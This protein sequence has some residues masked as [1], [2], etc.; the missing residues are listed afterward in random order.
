LL[1]RVLFRWCGLT[2]PSTWGRV[3]ITLV[4]VAYAIRLAGQLHPQIFIVDL[5]FHEHRLDTV[6][7]GTLLFTIES[8]EWAG[9]STYY[10]PS[11]YIFML[12][13]RW[14]IDNSQVV[15]R[16]FTVG[17]GTLGAVL[18]FLAGAVGLRSY[19]AAFIAAA[20][21]LAMP[22]SVLPFSWGITTNLFGEFF[23]LCAFT[24]LVVIGSS[25]R[26]LGPRRSAFWVL[27]ASLSVA[28]LS[29]PGVAQLS[30]A[31]VAL[32]CVL[33]FAADRQS[34]GGR[35]AAWA[36]AALAVSG[37]F[38]YVIY[39]RNVLPDMLSTL[40]VIRQERAAESPAMGLNLKVGG[41]VSDRSLGLVVRY[42][43]NWGDWLAGGLAGFWNEARAYYKAWPFVG[44]G[45]GYVAL[46]PGWGTGRAYG[47]QR[48]WLVLVA[49]GWTL[50]ILLFAFVGWL[51]NLYVRYALFALPVVALGVGTL[52]GRVWRDSRASRLLVTLL[53]VFFAVEA[54][55]LWHYRINYG[56]K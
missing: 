24:A 8:A 1:A 25:G 53:V 31:A 46:L 13:L 54:L 3:L 39:Y 7:S 17:V 11:A 45:L 43:N 21:Y 18:I 44:A 15:V 47:R 41:S 10:L 49:A 56:L 33:W 6:R 19:R 37:L 12:P 14:L 26:A 50:A 32:V 30:A 20:L 28:I 27:A 36:F 5:G 40:A 35:Q 29:H 42:V 22:L 34:G 38:A 51:L 52:L 48:S 23:A 55:A 4:F 2:W 16:L 9:H